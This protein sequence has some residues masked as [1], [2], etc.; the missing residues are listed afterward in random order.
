MEKPNAEYHELIDDLG[1]QK[2]YGELTLHFQGGAI[3]HSLKV[4]RNTTKEIRE[5]MAAKKHRKALH[6][7]N[8]G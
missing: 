7:T 1:E 3:D 8:K 2:F 4:E 5:K 6:I